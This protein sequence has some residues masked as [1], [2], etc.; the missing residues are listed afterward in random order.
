M[1]I[2]LVFCHPRR[3]SLTGAVANAFAEGA[4][5]SG[6][7]IEWAD[8]YGEGFDP[9]L[10]PDDEPD[11]TI[12]NKRYSDTVHRE[13]E[14]IDRNDAIVMVFPIWW[15]SMPAMLK[16]WVDRVWNKDWAYGN[17]SLKHQHGLV[18]GLGANDVEGFEKHDYRRAMDVQMPYGVMGYCGIP[19][20]RMVILPQAGVDPEVTERQL[21]QTKQLGRT[22]PIC[23][24]PPPED[25]GLYLD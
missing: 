7:E 10:M 8:L 9:V 21:A 5:E 13:M 16:G 12:E 23:T 11:W 20:N 3:D 25:A 15:W 6:H 24:K 14:R 1:K 19:E 18:I 17:K 4:A 22:F 2:L